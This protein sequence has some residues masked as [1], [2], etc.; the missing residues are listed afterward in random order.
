MEVKK[1]DLDKIIISSN[2]KMGKI[3]EW[4]KE[5]EDI[6]FDEDGIFMLPMKQG[7]VC[8]E[9]EDI[10][11][12]FK[13]M[14]DGN[15]CITVY[16]G[17][18]DIPTFMFLVN[19]RMGRESVMETDNQDGL[20]HSMKFF[21]PQDELKQAAMKFL[22][23]KDMTAHK[24][25]IKLFSLMAFMAY[26]EEIVEV[27]ENQKERRD[28]RSARALRQNGQPLP[29]WK[30]TYVVKDFDE[31][32]LR[33]PGEPRRYTKPDH[34]VGVRGHWR[35]LKSGKKTWIR[36]HVNYKGKGEKKPKTYKA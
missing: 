25:T 3:I 28:R 34:E 14:H 12:T 11:F 9:E 16:M 29:L 8:L 19:A 17:R 22:I 4:A 27:D 30:K 18:Y 21:G 23:A 36:E 5:H 1:K 33:L 32:N 35:K 13:L 2:E 31:K 26:Y 10:D 24:E 15:I 7:L 6:I 20:I